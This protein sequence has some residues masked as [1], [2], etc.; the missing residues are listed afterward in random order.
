VLKR[1][2]EQEIENF[3]LNQSY[4]QA[5]ITDYTKKIVSQCSVYGIPYHVIDTNNKSEEDVLKEALEVIQPL[6]S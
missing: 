1:G 5:L 4:F 3:E 2:R 6:R